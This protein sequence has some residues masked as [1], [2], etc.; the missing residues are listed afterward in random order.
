MSAS[1]SDIRQ[2]PLEVERQV[3]LVPCHREGCLVGVDP[4]EAKV[5]NNWLYCSWE[6]VEQ[7][8]EQ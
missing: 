8:C 6:C 7:D 5:F 2:T 3:T 4:D 1:D